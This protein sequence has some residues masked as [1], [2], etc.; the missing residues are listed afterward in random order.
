MSYFHCNKC[1]HE[2]EAYPEKKGTE[3]VNP[4][5]DWCGGDSYILEENTP[6]ENTMKNI[7]ELEKLIKECLSY[8]YKKSINNR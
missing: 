1:H 6:L 7:D 8:E 5:C 4:R 2:F 3:C